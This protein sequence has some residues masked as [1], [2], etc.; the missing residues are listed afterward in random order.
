M[1]TDNCNLQSDTLPP[2]FICRPNIRALAVE[3][4][5]SLFAADYMS[6]HDL[7]SS[8]G[9]Q[10]ALKKLTRLDIIEKAPSGEWKVVDPILK[11]WLIRQAG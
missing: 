3:E 2:L 5:G 8:G 9:I 7:G 10:G 1:N 4:T 11:L 6:R